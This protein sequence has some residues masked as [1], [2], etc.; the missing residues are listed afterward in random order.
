MTLKVTS[1]DI[2]ILNS[3]GQT[4][5]SSNQPLVFVSGYEAG[6]SSVGYIG[7]TFQSRTHFWLTTPLLENEIGVIYITITSISGFGDPGTSFL[8]VRQPANAVIPIYVRGYP[9]GN[10]P[11]ADTTHMSIAPVYGHA[12]ENPTFDN[13][14][15]YGSSDIGITGYRTTLIYYAFNCG[16]APNFFY[17]GNQG[18]TNPL[19]TFNWEVYKYRYLYTI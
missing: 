9:N 10:T 4:K 19:I 1:S 16:N 8:N 13:T 5:F 17:S 7:G 15:G 6:T 18:V 14:L 2:Q 12:D 11:A 3:A